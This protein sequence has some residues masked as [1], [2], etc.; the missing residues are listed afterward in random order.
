MDWSVRRA[1]LAAADDAL[2]HN[3]LE[4]RRAQRAARS[5]ARVRDWRLPTGIRN[6]AV[7]I[8]DLV[9]FKTEPVARFLAAVGRERHW[10][11]KSEPI[12]RAF[13][14]DMFIELMASDEAPG[15]AAL[16]DVTEPS[17]VL[18]MRTARRWAE[19]WDLFC[20]AERQN[21]ERGV[22]PS[23]RAL[24]VR[25]TASRAATGQA[26]PGTTAQS[27]VRKWATK[28]RR[29]WGGRFGSIPAKDCVPLDELMDKV[30]TP[31]RWGV[32]GTYK[33][34]EQ[35]IEDVRRQPGQ[36][37]YGFPCRKTAP[38]TVPTRGDIV[39]ESIGF[40]IVVM[41]CA[42]PMRSKLWCR[43]AARKSVPTLTP[44]G[45]MF[46]AQPVYTDTHTPH[47]TRHWNRSRLW[48]HLEAICNPQSWLCI[49]THAFATTLTDFARAWPPHRQTQPTQATS[50]WQW[51]N[52][53]EVLAAARGKTLLRINVDETAVCLHP[54]SGK[55]AVFVTKRWLRCGGGQHVPKW[56]RR[57]Y[58]SH[59]A[60]ICDRADIQATMP[61]FV[62]GNE[63]TLL[64]RQ[65]YRLR[66]GRPLNVR[67]IRQKSAWSSGRLTAT[68]VRHIAA[69][70]DGRS[71]RALDVQV[72][73]LLDAA[74][75]HFTPAVLRACKAANFWL[76][77][78][79][80]R[81]T[82]LIQ[83]LDTDA[84]ALYK[85]WML[86]AY[87]DAR[88]RSA[89]ADGDLTMA[90]FLPC[91][92]GAIQSVLEA[93][94]WAVA[95]DRDGFG[96]GQRA[97][98]DRVKQGLQLDGDVAVPSSRPSNVQLRRCFPRN[99]RPDLDVL[100]SL[101]DEVAAPPPLSAHLRPVDPGLV[102]MHAVPP[103]REPFAAVVHRR[104]VAAA[105]AAAR[106]TP[107]VASAPPLLRRY[108]EVP[109][110]D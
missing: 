76:I 21:V 79:P 52:H 47:R 42:P 32:A 17:D 35:C 57:R 83:P 99:S 84:F 36:R 45:S 72:L 105:H 60:V 9:G 95:F 91:I 8:Y 49:Y 90:E 2:R 29:R 55:G 23:T 19:E 14:E 106:L 65:I 53:A 41:V 66:R 104:E 11:V 1:A 86:A 44:H 89:N 68:L 59:I 38:K 13:V 25:L 101:F 92:D 82:F 34:C 71:G 15:V 97:L 87:Q 75:I 98:G 102:S 39:P 51:Y 31:R 77:V 43:K 16:V 12:M 74:K 93:R 6:T 61:Q 22:T 94:P 4:L 54:G 100:W 58:M 27:K 78:I 40:T 96:A 7:I 48:H 63:R 26:P 109:N 69:A 5:A 107:G 108:R 30:Q 20:W 80:P 103:A 110:L 67:L 33:F 24:L 88:S 73:L 3:R 10:R 37:R 56:K 46:V 64:A 70:L 18:A 81:L 62:V 50:A 28:F 85:S